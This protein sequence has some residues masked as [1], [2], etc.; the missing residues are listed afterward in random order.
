MLDSDLA[1][2]YDVEIRTINQAVKR[3]IERFPEDFSFIPSSSEM[4]EL[5]S[6]FVILGH[7][8]AENHFRHA[9][10][11]FSENGV[12]MLS[13]VLKSDRAIQVNIS[14]MRT[15]TKLREF[16]LYY[17]ALGKKFIE[18]E[19]K[20]DKQFKEVFSILDKLVNET[21]KTDE[22]VMGFIQ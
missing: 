10:R 2:L 11:L 22:K 19:R 4:A 8:S 18:L 16:T 6:Q 12:A 21:K 20:N 13:S 7:V 15:F 1:R 17:N 5:R 3:N 9:P 14:I